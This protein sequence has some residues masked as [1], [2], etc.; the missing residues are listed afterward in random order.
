MESIS[1]LSKP[2]SA[3]PVCLANQ[4]ERMIALAYSH[5]CRCDQCGHYYLN[6]ADEALEKS[7]AELYQETYAGFRTDPLFQQVIR[8]ELARSFAPRIAAPARILDVG[9][10]NGDFLAAA[11]EAGYTATG[12][13]ISEASAKICQGRGLTAQAGDF[14]T[15]ELPTDFDFVTM[16]DVVEHLPE[17]QLFYRRAFELL[18]PGGYLVIKTPYMAVQTMWIVKK[19]PRLAG[20]LLQ[21]PHHIQWY[22]RSTLQRS[23]ESTGFTTFD[24]LTDRPMRSKPRAQSLKKA[25]ARFIIQLIRALGKNGNL[26]VMAR[27]PSDTNGKAESS[28]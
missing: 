23:L 8:E 16:W 22:D 17:P 2:V 18:K 4:P 26:F 7:F 20:A 28:A 12:L 5:I 21:V 15:V 24:W 13:D 9:C 10:G 1:P 27:K 14:L 25:V 19:I 6:L 11:Q 3:C